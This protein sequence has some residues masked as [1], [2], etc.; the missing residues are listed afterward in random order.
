M[1]SG[2]LE[3]VLRGGGRAPLLAER[4]DVCGAPLPERHR[5]LLDTERADV[6]CACRPCSL[7]FVRDVASLGHYRL[8]PERR[9]R[10]GAVATD[11]LGV[12]VGLA[13]VVRGADDAVVA[14]YPSPLGSTRWEVDPPAW[15]AVVARRPEL[16]GLVPEVEAFLVNTARGARQHWIVPIDDCFRLIAVVRREWR[17]LSGGSRVWPAVEEFFADLEHRRE[18]EP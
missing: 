4:C 18:E 10:L 3:R 6:M 13:Y 15:Q 12:P 14:H 5:H 11:E 9:L 8:V 7:L 17:G 16:A 1:S 2:A